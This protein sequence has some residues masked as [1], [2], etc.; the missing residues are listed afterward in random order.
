MLVQDST[1]RIVHDTVRIAGRE[2]VDTLINIHTLRDTTYL[3]TERVRVQWRVITDT[4]VQLRVDCPADTLRSTYMQELTKQAFVHRVPADSP[5]LS[6]WGVV[7]IVAV[8]VLIYILV[9]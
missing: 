6:I 1:L 2:R 9:R 8:G 3:T 4:L 7:V 5:A